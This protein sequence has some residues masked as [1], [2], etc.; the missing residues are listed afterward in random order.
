MSSCLSLCCKIYYLPLPSYASQCG[1]L[2]TGYFAIISLFLQESVET[3]KVAYVPDM[4]L[5]N[6]VISYYEHIYIK[7]K[8]SAGVVASALSIAM[9]KHNLLKR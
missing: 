2:H 4:R 1:G 3:S 9:L 7:G 8:K 6:V 5:C